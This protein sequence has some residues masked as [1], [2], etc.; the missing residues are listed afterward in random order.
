MALIAHQTQVSHAT[1]SSTPISW[2]KGVKLKPSVALWLGGR[3]DGWTSL[4]HDLH[5]SIGTLHVLGPVRRPLKILAFKGSAQNDESG[6][7]SRGY[8]LAKDSVKLSY[9]P[10][11]G[12]DTAADS[13]DV[14]NVYTSEGDETA[15]GS[16]AIQKL[17]KKWLMM[18]HTQS[19]SLAT[20]GIL[21]VAPS[22]RKL[23]EHQSEGQKREAVKILKAAWC[24]F[25]GV[26][27]TIKIPLL[28]FIPLYLAVNIVYG[29][30]VS[31]DLKPL[32]ILGPLIMALY[33]KMLRWLW[34]LYIFT[35]K[36]AMGE[37]KNLPTY[38]LLAYNYMAQG[39]LKED[40][41]TRFWQPMLDIK[42]LDYKTFSKRRLKEFEEWVAEKYLD[43]VESIWPF[44][45]RTIRF[46]KKA[47]LI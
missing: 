17:L 4:N 47:N 16:V 33:I 11:E 8:Y 35:F 19:S 5:L 22:E 25:L 32:W 21:G 40:I 28:I 39:K 20:N 1:F 2:T 42:N 30:E 3:S 44:Y 26:D 13:P 18:L 31:K 9:V 24:C 15:A 12:E 6:S 34:A 14:Q 37:A 38:Y 41:Q 36:Q 43:Y 23:S 46:L 27:A 7:R 29:P 10:H 45:C